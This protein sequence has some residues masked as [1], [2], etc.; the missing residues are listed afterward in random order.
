MLFRKDISTVHLPHN[1]HTA[2][3]A[4]APIA[5]PKEVVIPMVMHSGAQ[6]VP[7]VAV[8]DHVYAG[9]KIAKE[10]GRFSVPQHAT[11]SGTV[12]AIENI[13]KLG[14]GEVLAIR[15]E[16]DGKMEMDPSMTAPTVT[17]VDEFLQACLDSG[18]VGLGGAAFP[19]WGKLDAVRRNQIHTVLVNGAECE[20]YITA[21]HRTMLEQ[22]DYIVKGIALLKKYLG[23]TRFVIGI[24]NTKQD[25]IDKLG[26]TFKDAEQVEILALNAVYP[27]GAKQVLLY[28]ACNVVVEEGQRLASKGVIIINVTTLAKMAEF[29]E[30]GR[31]LIDKCITVD[32]SAIAN[33]CNLI[34]PIGTPVSY[35]VEQAGGF[36]TEPG[37]VIIGGPMM[38]VALSDLDEPIVK[39]SNAVVAFT[40]EECGKVE[41]SDC[42]RCGRCVANCPISL[43][44]TLYAK[45]YETEDEEKRFQILSK[46]RVNFCIECG[47]CS[48]VCPAN[49]PLLEMNIAGKQFLRKAKAARS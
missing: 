8:G 16:S 49:R 24:E 44:P 40:P 27:Q 25:A 37:K 6:S 34:V 18:I 11:V 41:P 7:V 12:K 43:N 42:I 36:K 33:P 48:Y 26:E 10:E 46:E 31:P 35:I 21:D 32:G 22:T 5:P 19:L 30:T 39:A 13:K 20:P 45:A 4:S 3:C 28:N 29:M 9:Q 38:G 17:N 1:K 23:S 15:I 14:G 47:C 2:G